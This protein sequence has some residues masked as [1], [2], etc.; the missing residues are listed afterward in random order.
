MSP[1]G[2]AGLPDQSSRNS[3]NKCQLV[4][5]LTAPFSFRC[6]K[7]CTRYSLSKICVLAKVDQS[8]QKM[9]DNLLRT[10]ALVMPNFIMLGQTMYEKSSTIF[11]TPF[12]IFGAPGGLWA[13][14]H[15]SW[16]DVQQVPLYQ[17]DKF[18]PVLKNPLGDIC[19]QI[20][21]ISLMAWPTKSSKR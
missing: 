17:R 5:P 2:I 9:W 10:N 11:F 8:S 13:K 1:H 19:C 18:R 20:S 15:Q 21:S 6:N 7:K 3:G 16:P 14:V 12:S 4:R